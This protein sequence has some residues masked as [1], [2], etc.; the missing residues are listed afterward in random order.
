MNDRAGGVAFRPF[1]HSSFL[2]L[3]PFLLFFPFSVVLRSSNYVA[4][5][6]TVGSD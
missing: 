3:A 6:K 5:T 4:E 2:S 1:R